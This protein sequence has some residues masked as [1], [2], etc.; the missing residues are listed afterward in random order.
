MSTTSIRVAA[1]AAA[2]GALAPAA[3]AAAAHLGER[4]LRPGGRGHDVRELQRLLTA[5]GVRTRADGAFGPRTARGVR[6]DQR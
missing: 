4:A 3:P 2:V 5:V 1:A 6:R